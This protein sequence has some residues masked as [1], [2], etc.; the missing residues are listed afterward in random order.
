MNDSG[1]NEQ[2]RTE[3]ILWENEIE[4]NRVLVVTG[5]IMAAV[6]SIVWVLSEFEVFYV[7]YW[8]RS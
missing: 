6:F 1:M 3:D 4:A 5:V 8:G 2:N 7:Y